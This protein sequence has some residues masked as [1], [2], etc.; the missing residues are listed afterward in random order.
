MEN[1]GPHKTRIMGLPGS[2]N[3]VMIGRAVLTQY[4]RVM[5]GQTDRRTDVQPI[6]ITCVSLL[7]HVKNYNENEVKTKTKLKRNY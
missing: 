6:A 5:D 4:Q 3:S 2:E 1:V 7:M